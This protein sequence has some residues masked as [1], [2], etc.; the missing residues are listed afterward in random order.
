MQTLW[1]PH[2]TMSRLIHTL[3]D[4]SGRNTSH[5]LASHDFLTWRERL[6]SDRGGDISS[7]LVFLWGSAASD[8]HKYTIDW[9]PDYVR[10]LIDDAE[11]RRLEPSDLQGDGRA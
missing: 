1:V 7:E 3:Q 11:V 5:V 4:W 2:D 10:W 6:P 9:Q 8:F